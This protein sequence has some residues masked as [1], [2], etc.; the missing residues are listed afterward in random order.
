MDCDFDQYWADEISS[1]DLFENYLSRGAPVLI[2]GL[3]EE[4]PVIEKY[5]RDSLKSVHGLLEVQ[6]SI[7]INKYLSNK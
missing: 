3:I 2:R 4:W 1:D 5:T 7:K 6:V